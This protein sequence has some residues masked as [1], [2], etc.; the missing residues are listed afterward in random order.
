MKRKLI[1][2]INILLFLTISQELMSQDTIYYI[3]TDIRSV[4]DFSQEPRN[5]F[6]RE[7][8]V[9]SNLLIEYVNNPIML[10]NY[11]TIQSEFMNFYK[12]I[13][14]IFEYPKNAIRKGKQGRVFTNFI[15]NENGEV[16]EIKVLK[17]VC[18]EID[19]E[20]VRIINLYI[21]PSPIYK[22]KK[23]SVKIT[24]PIKFTLD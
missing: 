20:A 13:G 15:I 17:G 24:M 14:S 4:L 1:L 12:F 5:I 2:V 9:D 8:D 21:W 3:N 10:D 6:I 23:T 22:G 11:T 16:K 19:S 7:L 18:D